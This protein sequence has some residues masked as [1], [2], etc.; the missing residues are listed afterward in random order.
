MGV[1]QLDAQL[2]AHFFQLPPPS[3]SAYITKMESTRHAASRLEAVWMDAE[4]R[5]HFFQLPRSSCSAHTISF[6]HT[7]SC[8]AH[9]KM[10]STC[11]AWSAHRGSSSR[12]TTSMK[13]IVNLHKHSR[14]STLVAST[15]PHFK[16]EI[17]A[18]VGLPQSHGQLHRYSHPDEYL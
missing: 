8:S 1:V 15:P 5:S 3:C 6:H 16:R 18:N 13:V 7:L 4:M 9:M 2:D 17:A 11:T 12:P 14:L 10:V